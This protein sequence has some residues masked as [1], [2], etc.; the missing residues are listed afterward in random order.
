MRLVSTGHDTT[1]R[2]SPLSVTN[3]TKFRRLGMI[4]YTVTSIKDLNL[5]RLSIQHPIL[6][7]FQHEG[8]RMLTRVIS[9]G[10]LGVGA[11]SPLRN[12]RISHGFRQ[13]VSPGV[14]VK[15]QVS[16]PG[17]NVDVQA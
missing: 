14:G 10:D 12:L 11:N 6:P 3:I 8:L 17:D 16:I 5:P 7:I 13:K 9:A 4:N 2:T 1:L 15:V